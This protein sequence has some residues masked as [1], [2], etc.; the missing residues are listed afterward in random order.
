MNDFLEFLTPADRDALL[1][2]AER[3][4]YRGGETILSEGEN[5]RAIFIIY[6]GDAR[7]ERRH[8]EFD[9]EIAQLAAGEIFGEMGFVE[10]FEASA[11]V[12]ANSDCDVA[13]IDAAEVTRM[14]DE[15]PGF[16]GRFYQSLAHILSAR[17]R[18]TTDIGIAE[19]A[20]GGRP[21][22]ELEELRLLDADDIQDGGSEPS[23]AGHWG[24]G[25]PLRDESF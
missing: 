3:K 21:L 13:E 15:N 10:G 25:S 19:Y 23:A 8:T 9:V 17:L 6:S 22:D 1:R 12:V 5:R 20:W 4:L 16:Y 11:S 18:E 14:I 2:V 24:G 7:V